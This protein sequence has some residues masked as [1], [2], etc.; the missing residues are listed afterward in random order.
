[1]VELLA[2]RL[3]RKRF[4]NT[5]I[6]RPLIHVAT[7]AIL[8]LKKLLWLTWLF[9]PTT[10][11]RPRPELFNK[12]WHIGRL[13]LRNEISNPLDV[14]ATRARPA[15]AADDHPIDFVRRKLAPLAVPSSEIISPVE[16]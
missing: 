2:D 8:K 12:N 15:L 6:F 7:L 16:F 11:I 4:P 5:Q 10:T 3:I 9:V 1:M 14:T 13:T